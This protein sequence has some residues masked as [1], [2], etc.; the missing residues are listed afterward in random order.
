VE[1]RKVNELP[2]NGRNVFNLIELAASLVP[3]GR[4]SGT[5]VGVNPFGWGDH[6]VN[7][8]FGNESAEYLDGQPLNTGYI[9]LAILIPTQTDYLWLI[10][11]AA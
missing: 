11:F 2:L 10:R 1:Q 5:P 8:A 7:G 4:S 9:N 3:Q 6:Q